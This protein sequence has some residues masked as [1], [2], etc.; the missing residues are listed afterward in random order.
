MC[1]ILA[2]LEYSQSF[3]WLWARQTSTAPDDQGQCTLSPRGKLS[4]ISLVANGLLVLDILA[5]IKKSS[6]DYLEQ[7]H[8]GIEKKGFADSQLKCDKSSM[9]GILYQNNKSNHFNI[10]KPL[11]LKVVS[12]WW[13]NIVDVNIVNIGR[14]PTFVCCLSLVSSARLHL[15][16]SLFHNCLWRH[17]SK[18][19]W[20]HHSRSADVVLRFVTPQFETKTK[21]PPQEVP[22]KNT[23][24]FD[25]QQ[26]LSCRHLFSCCCV[27]NIW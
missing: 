14:P 1:K 19:L 12:N 27:K 18:H 2:N 20:Y 23:C 7:L 26:W 15:S 17:T 13:F 8:P 25:D 9:R 4:V 21:Q 5:S 10:L 24:P 22:W 11:K 3:F 16:P 6:I